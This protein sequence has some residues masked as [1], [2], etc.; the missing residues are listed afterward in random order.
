MQSKFW[1]VWCWCWFLSLVI[2][3]RQCP[4]MSSPTVKPQQRYQQDSTRPSERSPS[5][6]ANFELALY[7]QALM[8]TSPSLSL[9]APPLIYQQHTGNRTTL[10]SGHLQSKKQAT[11]LWGK[12]IIHAKLLLTPSSIYFLLD[13]EVIMVI[14]SNINT[15]LK[16][17]FQILNIKLSCNASNGPNSP[18]IALF[19]HSRW[20]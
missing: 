20:C 10:V 9:V 4:C 8:P 19:S 14:N 17:L 2:Q 13:A 1:R 16:M 11:K 15:Y 5:S 18:R 7:W 6:P 3:R 12:I